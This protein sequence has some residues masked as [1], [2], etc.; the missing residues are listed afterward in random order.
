MSQETLGHIELEWTCRNCG[1]RN[2]GSVQVCQR[3]GSPMAEDQDFELPV[4]QEL[5]PAETVEA[6]V[7]EPAK[8]AITEAP[9]DIH[10]PY[11]GTR[12]PGTATICKRCGGDLTQGKAR[13]RG[14]VLGAYRA[15]QAPD[16]TCPHCGAQNPAT[17]LQCRQ[18]GAQNPATALQCRQ[19]GGNLTK[20]K[21][22]PPPPAAEKRPFPL[23]IALMVLLVVLGICGF[24]ALSLLRTE[25]IT[26]EVY[27]VSW[28]R[29]IAIQAPQLVTREAWWDDVPSGARVVMCEKRL[30]R[31]QAEPAPVSTK[32][33]GTPYVVDL[34]TGQGKVVQDCVYLVYEDYCQYETMAWVVIR[35]ERLTGSDLQPMWPRLILGS[36]EREAARQEEYA[37]VF[38]ND[39]TRYTYHPS[40]A[41]EFAQFQTGTVWKL[42]VNQLGGITSISR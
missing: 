5:T 27:D 2:K 7:Q 13:Q 25:E 31:E 33:C 15:G 16:V 11:C 19:C 3:C 9:P 6:T 26:A 37:V 39:G 34:G 36:N 18:C 20:P 29:S 4:Q 23:G 14:K 8:A 10:C 12:N 35:T 42:K 40:S 30:R 28:S 41:A 24:V 21:E 1:A 17:A 22:T 32:V 38:D